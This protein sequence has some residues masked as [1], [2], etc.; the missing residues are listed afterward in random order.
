MYRKGADVSSL[1][2]CCGLFNTRE[3]MLFHY[4]KIMR[5]HRALQNSDIIECILQ[6]FAPSSCGQA[7][8]VGPSIESSDV[9]LEG[10][11]A[12]KDWT[13]LAMCTRVSKAISGTAYRL[14][15]R[16]LPSLTPLLRLVCFP[17]D[18]ERCFDSGVS[19]SAVRHLA[20]LRP[21]SSRPQPLNHSYEGG[22]ASLNSPHMFCASSLMCQSHPRTLVPPSCALHASTSDSPSC[23]LSKRSV[24][25]AA[26]ISTI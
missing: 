24:A 22:N 14:L 9:Q 7:A 5:P 10:I 4:P 15:W 13:S 23:P 12:Q 11:A 6:Y 19:I 26:P 2:V 8:N 25:Q 17:P 20:I 3:L 21:Q 16:E 1:I 18:V